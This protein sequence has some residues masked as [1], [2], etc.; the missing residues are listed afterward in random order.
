MARRYGSEVLASVHETALGMA[1]AAVMFNQTMKVFD[2]MCLTAIEDVAPEDICALRLR[3]N[4]RR[5]ATFKPNS[6]WRIS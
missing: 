1:E 6:D 2:E 3:V 4:S 5:G